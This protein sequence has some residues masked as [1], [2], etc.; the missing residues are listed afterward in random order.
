LD[1]SF[2]DYNEG[3]LVSSVGA[4]NGWGLWTDQ[5]AE[6]CVVSADQ[7]LS[8]TNSGHVLDDGTTSSRATWSWSEYSE[9]KYSFYTNIYVPEN[10][11]GGFI[12]FHD[13]LNLEMPHSIS[14]LGDSSLL[15]L[16][17]EAF[18][19]LEVNNL[20]TGEWHEIHVIF[21]LDNATSEFIVDAVSIGTM[22][23]S[24]GV[25]GA[26]PFGSVEF[27]AYAYNPFTGQQPP[28]S[29]YIDDLN[30]V[31]E[32]LL[33]RISEQVTPSLKLMPN[34]SNGAFAIDFNGS[35]FEQAELTITNM[36]GAK[37]Y[38]KTLSVVSSLENFQT[39]IDAGVYLIEVTDGSRTWNSK[40]IIK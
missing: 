12:G 4:T 38:V 29:Y 10:S 39:S 37:V 3:D 8:G 26:I 17:W 20:A 13:S 35:S 30:L 25:S 14:I 19:Y 31:D 24:F 36:T 27:A 21:D 7:F 9:G 2:D 16:D 34:P 32:L 22:G 28:A 23:T 11:E 33:V 5:D 40:I 6:S 18:D 1:E 15:F